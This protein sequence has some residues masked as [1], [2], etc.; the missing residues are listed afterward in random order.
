MSSL[1]IAIDQ[2][3]TSCRALLFDAAFSIRDICQQEIRQIY[4]K[5]G[6]VEHDPM[7]ILKIQSEMV[8]SLV[9]RNKIGP[10][11]VS[12]IGITNQRETVVLWNKKTGIPVYNAIV[13]QDTRTTEACQKIKS[14]GMEDAI[15]LSTG[16]LADSYFSATKI[17]WIFENVKGVSE[18]ASQGLLMAG[19]MDSWLLWNFCSE[20]PHLTDTTNA[21]RTLLFD[22][23]KAKWDQHLLEYF[24]IPETI[25][26]N[27]KDTISHFGTSDIRVLGIEAPITAVAGDQ[28]AALF[29]QQCFQAGTAKNTYGTGCFM[30]MHT[31][32]IPVKSESRLLTTIAWS[33]R[34]IIEYA[35]EGSVFISGAAIQWLRD[36]LKIIKNAGD[37]EFLASAVQDTGGVYFVPA[38]AGMGAPFWEMD[39]RGAIFGITRSTTEKEIARAALESIAYQSKDVLD[40]MERDSAVSLC[41]IKADGGAATNNFLMQFQAD[42]LGIE[43]S[44][45]S[46]MESTALGVALMAGAGYGIHNRFEIENI[47][48]P[49]RIFTPKMS[50]E[51]KENKYKGWRKAVNAVC[52]YG[53]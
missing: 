10:R 46:V 35:L 9:Q 40:A 13:W 51:E 37:S 22:I 1:I 47:N 11:D 33:E 34:G 8:R 20:K 36:G 32:S 48:P 42:I 18:L 12:C 25:L 28:Q 19:T 27:V 15:S 30:L 4:P 50:S 14:D 26:P 49:E 52:H 38:F 5:P 16:L 29:G 6:W 2:G 21:S 23:R 31:G 53:K 17:K 44:R 24:A 45:S 3:T 41:S 43:V 7:E 39:A